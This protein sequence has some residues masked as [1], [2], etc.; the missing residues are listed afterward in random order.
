MENEILSLFEDWNSALKSGDS[1]VVAELYEDNAI[2]LPT[3]SNIV[4]R[5]PEDRIQYFDQFLA[6]KARGTINESNVR[7]FGDV[8]INSGVY[9]F[10]FK[11]DSTVKARFTFVYHWN[12]VKWKI[13]EH[14]SS[15]MP[16]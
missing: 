8:A 5:K 16:E 10:D 15:R 9:T 13:I 11:D 12:G 4:R 1:A 7:V 3:L 6:R 14:H 2:L